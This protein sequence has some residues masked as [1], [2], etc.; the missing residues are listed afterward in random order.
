MATQNNGTAP[1]RRQRV[2]LTDAVA[3]RLSDTTT[4]RIWYDDQLKGFA[5]RVGGQA[6][7][8]L[9]YSIAGRERRLT[10]GAL[11]AWPA[12]AAR[13]RAMELR[14]LVDSGQDPMAMRQ[15]E[16][17]A[18]TMAEL[19]DLYLELAKAKRSIADDRSMAETI[20]RPKWRHRRVIDITSD[21]VEALHAE[22]TKAGKPIRAN[23]VL[24][25]LST[26]FALAI[27]RKWISSNNPATGCPKN[28]ETR[29]E[30]YLTVEEIARLVEVLGSWPDVKSAVAVKL[31]LLLGC[32]RGELLRARWRQFDLV[33]RTWRKPPEATKSGKA[34]TIPLSVEA[35]RELEKLSR[36]NSSD[37]LFRNAAGNPWSEVSAWP[38]IRAAAGIGDVRIHDLRHS[39]ASLL[40]SQGVPLAVIS[41]VLG[42]A[43][44]TMSARYSHL[45]DNVLR[46]AVDGLGR[47]IEEHKTA[48]IPRS[49]AD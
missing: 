3:K 28:R 42:H 39:C 1:A 2:H 6:A 20:I 21:D 30:R 23:R 49:A 13:A 45:H 24:S 44:V 15:A 41:G 47:A 11:A 17:T 12:K 36:H 8:V 34:H 35:I 29:R 5:L 26:V 25:L 37:L 7:W 19:L 10:I 46:A 18:P 43:S 27:K 33:G 16:R 31:L 9:G 4:P 14:R 22:L 40:I 48:P 38:A 32:R